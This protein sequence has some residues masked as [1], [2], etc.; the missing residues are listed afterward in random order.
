LNVCAAPLG[1]TWL[2]RE[3][4]ATP[5]REGEME[6]GNFIEFDTELDRQRSKSIAHQ[7]ET[8]YGTITATLTRGIE[9]SR[10]VAPP[11]VRAARIDCTARIGVGR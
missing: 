5:V 2:P 10:T 4:P 11:L 9:G 8:V 3:M 7:V 1:P 6:G